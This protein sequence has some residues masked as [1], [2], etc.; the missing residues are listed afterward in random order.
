MED[1]MAGSEVAAAVA[2]AVATTHAATLPLVVALVATRA[3]LTMMEGLP[4][5]ATCV[6]LFAHLSILAVLVVV[7][8]TD[9]ALAA[10]VATA[11][12]CSAVFRA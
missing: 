8:V 1:A 10:R 2:M 7:A 4:S 11:T 12:D 9:S 3:V 6:C 5:G